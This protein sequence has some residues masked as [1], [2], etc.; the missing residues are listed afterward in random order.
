MAGEALDA[1]AVEAW[2]RQGAK[3]FPAEFSWWFEEMKA[4]EMV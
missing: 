3:K 1:R 4:K 2:F